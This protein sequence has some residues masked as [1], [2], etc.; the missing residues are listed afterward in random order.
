MCGI[1]KR[2]SAPHI[3]VRRAE[4]SDAQA[5]HDLIVELARAH[6]EMDRVAS[7]VEDI[8]R[9]GFG[10]DPAFEAL[11]AE[12]DGE[13]VGLCLYFGSYSTWRGQR[14]LYVQDLVVADRARGLGIGRR[15]LAEAAALGKARGCGYLRLSVD[16]ANARAK[17]FYARHGLA[18]RPAERIYQIDDAGLDRL[19]AEGGEA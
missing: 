13:P 4:R 12:L 16:A 15:L 10:D 1:A 6:D 3:A 11:L 9:D 19:A 14:G 2:S 5:I 18:A 8:A 7:G 17:A